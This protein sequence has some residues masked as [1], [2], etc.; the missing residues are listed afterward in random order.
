MRNRGRIL[1]LLTVVFS[2]LALAPQVFSQT[3]TV[4]VESK[5]SQQIGESHGILSEENLLKLA[6]GR[7]ILYVKAGHGY[8]AAQNKETYSSGDELQFE[9]ENLHTGPVEEIL[10][11]P[12]GTLVT[13]PTGHVL[14]ILPNLRRFEADP[15]HVLYE[16]RWVG[17]DYKDTLLEDWDST[18]RDALRLLGDQTA[19]VDKYT[20]YEVTINLEG[21][22]RT[23]RAMVLYHN[24]FQSTAEPRVD[25][26]DNIVGQGA[27]TQAL[28]EGRPP[29]RSPWMAYARTAKY[30]EYADAIAKRNGE[31]RERSEKGAGPWPGDWQSAD[32]EPEL[33]AMSDSSTTVA[34]TFLCDRD[35]GVCD[36]LSCDY[37]NCAAK[38][39][40][41]DGEVQAYS[42]NCLAYRSVGVRAS[43]NRKSDLHHYYGNHR[44]Q[45]DLQKICNYDASCNVLCQIDIQNFVVSDYGFTSDSCHV[46]GGEVSLQDS[47]NGGIASQGA[48]CTSVAGAGVKSCL[49]CLCDVEVKIIGVSVT[50]SDGI[51][52]YDHHLTD[53]CEHP[54]D[55]NAN[56]SACNGG[57]GGVCT[58]F[59]CDAFAI[60]GD[61][62]YSFCCP[63]PIV[64]DI[65]GNG[66]D[67]TNA[68]RG[69][70][71]DLNRDGIAEHLSW[72]STGS[73]DAFLV[74]DRNGN[75]TIN[76][77]AELFGN[78]TPQ[79]PSPSKNGF[80]ALAEYDEPAN[81]G[82]G[83]GRIDSH[84]AIFSSLRL[85]Q[86]TNHNGISEPNELH[87]LPEFGVYGI[88]LDYSESRRTDQYG[89]RF[90]YRSRLYDAHGAHVGRWAWDIFFVKQ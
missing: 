31:A 87:T 29:V 1:A 40:D 72:T 81:G 33:S 76:N 71:F 52:T 49:F 74:L 46:F 2:T 23:Y 36:P 25:F 16:A 13:K 62:N 83:D 84:D 11:R 12:Y 64:I 68:A 42:G 67:L 86:D 50:V 15:E 8:K 45:D 70:N 77:G 75:G 39:S 34:P 48:T 53:T 7:L 4:F 82:N 19:D 5:P 27:L 63:S 9:L 43:G 22:Q 73:D 59:S 30:R 47:S 14:R 55:C 10:D 58:N 60:E 6:Y 17:N 90:R 79:P 28:Y 61:P 44:A 21:R 57:G 85:W 38:A 88:G 66:F 80:L 69:V 56:P 37:P 41:G 32:N 20:S 89:N 51:W 35:P 3:T 54:T 26:A 65:A 78:F 24:G 18:V